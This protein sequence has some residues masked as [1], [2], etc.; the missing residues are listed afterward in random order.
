M[1]KPAAPENTNLDASSHDATIPSISASTA[2]IVR[3]KLA[4]ALVPAYQAEFDPDEAE[5]AGAFP[6]DALSEADALDSTHDAL[7]AVEAPL[8]ASGLQ[9]SPL[10]RRSS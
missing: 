3:A 6:E 1:N 10:D 4:D 5:M 9:I 7:G 2:D 8:P